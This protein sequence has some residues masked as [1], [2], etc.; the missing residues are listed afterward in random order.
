MGRLIGEHRGRIANTAGDIVLA[1]FPSVVDAVEC[2]VQ[3]QKRLREKNEGVPGW[4]V[5]LRRT[6]SALVRASHKASVRVR[7]SQQLMQATDTRSLGRSGL[8][9]TALGFGSAP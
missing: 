6:I 7:G 9:V 1:E 3:V 8:E 2:A 4:T 5:Q